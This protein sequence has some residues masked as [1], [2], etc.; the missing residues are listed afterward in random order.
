[1]SSIGLAT[2]SDG[3]QSIEDWR[4]HF[5]FNLQTALGSR[6]ARYRWYQMWN[7]TFILQESKHF[8]Q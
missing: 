2:T 7:E 5:D 3:L 8:L 4:Q 1:M 6:H